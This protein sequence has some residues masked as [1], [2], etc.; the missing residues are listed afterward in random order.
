MVNDPLIRI[1]RDM[2][3]AGRSSNGGWSRQQLKILG[4]EWPLKRGWKTRILNMDLRLFQ[5]DYDRFLSLK[6][7][8]LSEEVLA[9]RRERRPRKERKPRGSERAQVVA[10]LMRRAAEYG[11]DEGVLHEMAEEIESGLHMELVTA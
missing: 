5:Q 6:N 11:E 8:H 9:N 7:A 1:T 10:Y 3:I 4:V 2:I